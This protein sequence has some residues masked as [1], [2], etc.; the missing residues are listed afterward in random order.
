M[1]TGLLTLLLMAGSLLSL[2]YMRV[3]EFPYLGSAAFLFSVAYLARPDSGPVALAILIWA[4]VLTVGADK[5]RLSVVAWCLSL[6]AL[7]PILQT[8]FRGVYYGSLVPLTYTLKATGMPLEARI[9]NGLGFTLPFLNEVRW[10]A[11]LAC[12]G[13]VVRFSPRKVI[14]ALPPLALTAYQVGIGGDAWPYW[15]LVAPGMPCLILLALASVDWGWTELFRAAR[16]A[17]TRL[18]TFTGKEPLADTV[19]SLR[20][21]RPLLRACLILLGAGLMLAG[22]FADYLRPGSPGF[23]AIQLL[24]VLVGS[25]LCYAGLTPRRASGSGLPAVGVLLLLF[26][27][28]NASFLREAIFLD[29]PYKAEANRNHVNAALSILQYTTPAATVGVIQAGIIPYYTSRYAVDFLG[30]NDPYIASL[31]A[32]LHGGP[33]WYGMSSVPGHNKY[34]LEYSI[35]QRLP[36]YVESFVWGAQNLTYV[37]EA[38]YVEVSL[39]GPDPAFRRGDPTVLWDQIPLNKLIFP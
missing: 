11:L 14:L 2:T 9:E 34:D 22:L 23:G 19:A 38:E 25:L 32:N 33:S 24:L 5:R 3:R 7:F 37:F 35:H 21:S 4:G 29:L 20:L 1:E 26:I 17:T 30:K 13:A 15:R 36:T 6:Y 8:A 18:L 12:V 10:A 27:T 31:P 16:S 28:L 39:P